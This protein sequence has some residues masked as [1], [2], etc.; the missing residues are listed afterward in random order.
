M[1]QPEMSSSFRLSGRRFIRRLFVTGIIGWSY[2]IDVSCARH[3]NQLFGQ[4]IDPGDRSNTHS[5]K[6]TCRIYRIL[7]LGRSGSLLSR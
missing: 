5:V 4:L 3:H 2:L 6:L 1:G 7:L